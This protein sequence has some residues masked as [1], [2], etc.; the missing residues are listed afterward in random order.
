MVKL[1]NDIVGNI[2]NIINHFVFPIF[3]NRIS[4]NSVITEPTLATAAANQRA[5]TAL[6][7][8]GQRSAL[9]KERSV[10]NSCMALEFL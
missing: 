1:N 2:F 4:P 9:W 5:S 7:S 8:Q 10:S 6:C 3:L